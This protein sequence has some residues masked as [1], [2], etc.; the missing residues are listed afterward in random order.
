MAGPVPVPR[1][2]DPLVQRQRRRGLLLL[3]RLPGQGRRHQLRAGHRAPRLR[4]C[5]APAGRQGRHHH[6]RGRRR[7]TGQPA[8]QGV[9]RRHGAGHRVVP[10]APADLRRRRPGPRLPAQ[11]GLRRRGGAPVPAGMGA[12]RLGRP[13]PGAGAEPGDGRR[14]GPRVRQP[15]RPAAGRLPGPG[16]LPHLRPV[17]ASG[18]PRGTGAAG[19]L[20][21]GQVQE[22][23]RDADLLQAQDALRPQLGQAGHHQPRT[24][25]WCA[26]GTPTSSGCSARGWS[27]PWPPAARRWPRST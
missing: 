21:P 4:R 26:R 23:Q 18:G 7:R 10:P 1:G 5:R 22:L 25:W 24:R 6:P 20:R 19:E 17:R 8:A 9:P 16:P 11:P 13:V 2:E 14:G 3:L 27:G 15:S 12:R